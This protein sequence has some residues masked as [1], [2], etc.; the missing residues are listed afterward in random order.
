M[1]LG[2]CRITEYHLLFGQHTRRLCNKCLLPVVLL[3]NQL[4]SVVL[5]GILLISQGQHPSWDASRNMEKWWHWGSI[6]SCTV[7]RQYFILTDTAVARIFTVQKFCLE[8]SESRRKLNRCN[9]PVQWNMMQCFALK[10]TSA[11]SLE[12]MREQFHRYN[13]KGVLRG[14]AGREHI[15]WRVARLLESVEDSRHG[16]TQIGTEIIVNDLCCFGK[17]SAPPPAP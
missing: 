14:S 3:P 15:I 16:L 11:P 7:A 1:G 6:F 8:V 9:G 13:G 2:L 10:C 5:K 4:D 17:C 12:K